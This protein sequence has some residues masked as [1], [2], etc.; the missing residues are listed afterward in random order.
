M[1]ETYKKWIEDGKPKVFCDCGCNQEII[2][3]RH[4]KYY[5]IPK[6]IKGHYWKGKHHT[7][8]S[9]EKISNAKCGENNSGINN[10]FYG[11]HHSKDTIEKM[12]KAKEGKY[13][14]PNNPN[15]QGGISF[16][17]YCPKFNDDKK[18]EIRN[19]YDRK[20]Y[21]CGKEEKDNIT[22]SGKFQRLSVHHIDADKEQG[23]NG[24]PWKLIS[25]CIHCHSKVHNHKITVKEL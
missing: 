25:L 8:D 1:H 4:H 2:I 7:K 19:E 22:K 13:D 11:K 3:Q 18:E 15:W 21:I 20:C 23:C 16:E 6:Y 14:G 5:G 24:K 12:S 17:P 10:H 9:I